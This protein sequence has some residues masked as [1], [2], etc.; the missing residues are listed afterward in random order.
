[1]TSVDRFADISILRYEIPD[2]D[3]LPP[4]RKVLL[5]YLSKA[6]LYGRDIVW[7][8]NYAGNL[9]IRR[10]LEAVYRHQLAAGRP[11]G[12]LAV[13]LKRLWFANGIHHHYS[14]DKF[15]PDFGRE[16]LCGWM[17]GV[18][19][20]T[21]EAAVGTT[22]DKAFEAIAP[23]I[24]E[25]DRDARKVCLDPQR[26][27][28][29]D[30]AVNF[31]SGLTQRQVEE[32]YADADADAS[33]HPL[34][35][36]LVSTGGQPRE[37]VWRVGGRYSEC[38]AYVCHWLNKAIGVAEN[39]RQVDVIRRLIRF[40]ETG[41]ASDF[42]QYN[43]SWVAERE[44]GVDF[45]NGFIEVYSDPLG[46]KATW[47]SIVQLV[48]DE[49]TRRADVICRHAQWFEDHSPIDDEYRKKNVRGV[50]MRV[51]N[52][53]MLG[54]DCYPSTPIGVNLPNEDRIR[55]RYGSKSVSLANISAAH[56]KAAADNGVAREF[57]LTEAEW[58]RCRL[59]GA[60]GSELHTQLHECLGHGSG[61]MKPGCRLD[62]LKAYGSTI[63]E[64][65]ADLF[66][67]Y[68]MADPKM[69]E[70]GLLSDLDAAWAH[71]DSYLRNGLLV[72]TARIAQGKNLEESHMRNRMLVC[73]WVL[74]NAGPQTVEMIERNGKHYV[75]IRDYESLRRY[76]G[77]LL[78]KV[79]RIKSEGNYDEARALVE[80]YGIRLDPALHAEVAERYAA[81]DVAPFAGFVN[82]RMTPVMIN[83]K[84]A[85]VRI[86]YEET[87]EEQMLRYSQQ[88]SV[89][90]RIDMD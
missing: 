67:L 7:H 38:L 25:P 48:D 84:V 90:M 66:A 14:G 28:V 53:V 19:S 82:P 62:D 81:L 9:L 68:F 73:R 26:D 49:A 15:V 17:A 6:A 42:A 56:R 46:L 37:I 55:E 41:A 57:A 20:R 52:A 36:T 65:R 69:V 23:V 43:I 50:S 59:Y 12:R 76:F 74:D 29:T 60:V 85:D 10:A 78:R 30:S 45:I 80:T 79:Q 4:V 32:F 77:L 8:Q 51:I 18:P 5:F 88:Y 86:D 27:L 61:C 83:N 40:Y 58:Q 54:G 70:L 63:E 34:N 72:Q 39:E 47:E 21:F 71:Y 64:A 3:R 22:A 87:Y 75:A 44:A 16:E 24:F 11:D 35:S 31:Y 2:F 89:P 1:M 33:R 13:Y